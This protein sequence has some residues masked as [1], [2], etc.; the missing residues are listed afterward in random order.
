M[1]LFFDHALKDAGEVAVFLKSRNSL[2]HTGLFYCQHYDD[3]AVLIQKGLPTTP[4]EEYFYIMSFLD[5]LML[6]LLGY[7]GPYLDWGKQDS[8]PTKRARV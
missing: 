8:F 2:V 6:K 5:R 7:S 4:Q 3:N 1:P